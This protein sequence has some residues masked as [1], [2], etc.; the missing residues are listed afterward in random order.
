[1][2]AKVYFPEDRNQIK[3]RL[4]TVK[5][6]LPRRTNAFM[7]RIAKEL[8]QYM[9]A[10]HPW[11][12]RTGNAERGLKAQV[13]QSAKRYVTTIE[14][15]H[16]VYYGIYLEKGFEERYAIIQPTIKTKGSEIMRRATEWYNEMF[17]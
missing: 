6:H 9:K 4:S 14:L 16:S 1:M 13:T 17:M 7:K 3:I 8:E 5:G 2:A 10:N 11:Q 12:N 15:S